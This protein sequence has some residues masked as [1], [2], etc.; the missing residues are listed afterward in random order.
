MALNNQTSMLKVVDNE[1]YFSVEVTPEI[2]NATSGVV[3]TPATIS[4]EI[5]TIPVGFVMSVTPFIDEND[6]VTLNVRPTISRIISR[7]DDPNPELANAGVTSQIPVV[8]VR[9]IESVLKINNGDT[10]VIGGLMQDQVNKQQSGVPILSSLPLIGG[11]FS[12]QDDEYV[13]SELVIFIR[14]VVMYDASLTGDLKDYRKY[15]LEDLEH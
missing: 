11:L 9:E 13:K 6:V 1:V 10:A 7:V 12:Y 4:T 2:V 3:T 8:Q 15:L 5:N 14:P